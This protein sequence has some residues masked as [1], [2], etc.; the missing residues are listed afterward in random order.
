MD[1]DRRQEDRNEAG[2]PVSP[3]L[4]QQQQQ[5]SDPEDGQDDQMADLDA[6]V[7]DLDASI[8]EH[9]GDEMDEE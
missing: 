7:E 2:I 1:D 8:E 5:M 9:V 3:A 4:M 6:S